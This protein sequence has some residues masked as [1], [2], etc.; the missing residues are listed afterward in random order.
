MAPWLRYIEIFNNS[1]YAFWLFIS[2]DRS[3]VGWIAWSVLVCWLSFAP[4]PLTS[5]H[6]S[7][8][9]QPM[10]I[11]ILIECIYRDYL[12]KFS[13]IFIIRI[14]MLLFF[15]IDLWAWINWMMNDIR[16][17]GI[18]M[19]LL[20]L[21]SNRKGIRL[22][23][24]NRFEFMNA[25]ETETLIV[26][27]FILFLFG[28]II[29]TISQSNWFFVDLVEDHSIITY[30]WKDR[31]VF[32]SFSCHREPADWWRANFSGHDWR[33]WDSNGP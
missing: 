12:L 8:P 5:H 16:F 29:A 7:D 33:S 24:L 2:L 17:S 32:K 30:R 21:H 15:A 28:L 6:H 22:T 19:C 4:F 14:E 18:M 11:Y 3:F 25:I 23:W 9:T 10:K 27:L 13:S 31:G 26:I 20:E 1:L